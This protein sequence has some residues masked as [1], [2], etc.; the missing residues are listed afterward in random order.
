M[1]SLCTLILITLTNFYRGFTTGTFYSHAALGMATLI[2]SSYPSSVGHVDLYTSLGKSFVLYVVFVLLCFFLVVE[3]VGFCVDRLRHHASTMF[4]SLCA[5][6]P[7]IR[8]VFSHLA[9]FL[10]PSTFQASNCP[11][12]H[13]R[14]NSACLCSTRCGKWSPSPQTF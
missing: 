1:G 6:F 13:H 4:G 10:N 12:I 14:R 2:K 8:T 5:Y 9:C 7:L 3:F 11:R